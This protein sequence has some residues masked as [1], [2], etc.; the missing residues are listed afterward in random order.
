MKT[1]S[2]LGKLWFSL[3]NSVNLAVMVFN[4]YF[5]TSTDVISPEVKKIMTN[6]G[7]REK[8]FN[9]INDLKTHKTDKVDLEF[10]DKKKMT[11]TL[12]D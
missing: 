4:Q 5:S 1:F 9:A 2:F 11:L 10:S 8:Y 12:N 6:P 7:D 3:K